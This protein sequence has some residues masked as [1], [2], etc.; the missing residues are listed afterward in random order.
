V[1]NQSQRTEASDLNERISFIE[2]NLT[3]AAL[4]DLAP[5]KPAKAR[6]DRHQLVENVI[7][8]KPWPQLLTFVLS[9]DRL[10][11]WQ[12]LFLRALTDGPKSKKD[13]LADK[14]V[15]TVLSKIKEEGFASDPGNFRD[16]KLVLLAKYGFISLSRSGRAW[17]YALNDLIAA[18]VRADLSQ[19][20]MEKIMARF[21]SST[22][23]AFIRRYKAPRYH[24]ESP[25]R[26]YIAPINPDVNAKPPVCV[27]ENAK[28]RR[29]VSF[30]DY[31]IQDVQLLL[32]FIGSLDPR[33]DVLLYG[34]DDVSRFGPYPSNLLEKELEETDCPPYSAMRLESGA[35]IFNLNVKF[36]SPQTAIK[37][38]AQTISRNLSI[39][40][41]IERLTLSGL[42]PD[43]KLDQIVR[44]ARKALKHA[45][46]SMS[47]RNFAVGEAFQSFGV[48][49][50]RFRWN[51][52][53]GRG[54]D[55]SMNCKARS[56]WSGLVWD[57]PEDAPRDASAIGS[58]LKTKCLVL[59]RE[60]RPSKKALLYNPAESRNFFEE[61]ARKS[62]YGIC[63]VIGN[64]DY[65]SV[66]SVIKGMNV[67]NVN[68]SPLILGKYAII[69]MEGSPTS[70]EEP[71]IGVC[72]Y[73]EDEIKRHLESFH[74]YAE[75]KELIVVSHAPPRGILDHAVRFGRRDIGSQSL[76]KFIESNKSVKLVICGHV[77]RCGGMVSKLANAS[78]VNAASHDNY[79]EPGRVAI[80]D[81]DSSGRMK[82]EWRFMY[83]LSGVYGV[84]PRTLEKLRSV[85][86][87]KVEDLL[88]MEISKVSA[89]ANVPIG[90]LNRFVLHAKALL[91]GK[92]LVL[93]PF[94]KPDGLM[95]YLD[96]ET[97]LDQSLVWLVGVYSEKRMAFRSFLARDEREEKKM[98][99]DLV[100]FISS[101]PEAH[102]GFYACTGFDRRVLE[103]RLAANGLPTELCSKMID[104][105]LPLRKAVAF[106]LKS[107]G[108]KSLAGY[109]GYEYRHPD[110]DGFGVAILYMDEYLDTHDPALERRLLE[111]NKDDVMFL[112][113]LSDQVALLAEGQGIQPKSFL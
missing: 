9:A 96:I 68:E 67:F 39:G 83:E 105:C 106:P 48:E 113:Q 49:R 51:V 13:I 98:L 17:T 61:L 100:E 88:K 33:P 24:I 63:A 60:G 19:V 25:S 3:K 8:T 34:G 28:I 99:T 103:S 43:A 76:R 58:Y 31:R 59:V 78:V 21:H 16:R 91:T 46:F 73:T 85:N 111:Y 70:P 15:K 29:I 79:G 108:I 97:N 65:H 11:W 72:L 102:I 45:G 94:E 109:F 35:S 56:P 1:T 5:Q 74:H 22:D 47:T 36:D 14:Q 95:L 87:A 30:S 4:I 12:I 86:I 54:K 2:A 53:I 89:A 75:N 37:A 101:E 40:D 20:K 90:T 107:Y 71:G 69:G 55:G 42:E 50:D 82:V 7:A 112:K 57:A 23:Y 64:D 104:L 27:N 18:R 6:L 110:L 26:P 92:P 41:S 77:H 62:T 93:S 44:R 66:S 80:I 10:E 32:D 52:S 81:M 84:G 38:L